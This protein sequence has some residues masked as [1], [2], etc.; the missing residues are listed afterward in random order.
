MKVLMKIT[1]LRFTANNIDAISQQA[2]LCIILFNPKWPDP[3]DSVSLL[4]DSTS[5]TK[6]NQLRIV[7]P[8]P[9]LPAD[10]FIQP[11]CCGRFIDPL[12]L[13]RFG[14]FE[15]ELFSAFY[16][17]AASWLVKN[18]EV[19]IL[20]RR[21]DS[22]SRQ[23]V[24]LNQVHKAGFMS[25]WWWWL[26]QVRITGSIKPTLCRPYSFPWF[27][28]YCLPVVHNNTISAGSRL[29]VFQMLI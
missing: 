9:L 26:N 15:W 6:W 21:G 4:I 10:I 14:F 25:W 12:L 8:P 11:C 23:T 2:C 20:N 3:D 22:I 24:W 5:M 17:K 27:T 18:R 19:A 1:K 28:S 16:P 7:T 13:H 29:P